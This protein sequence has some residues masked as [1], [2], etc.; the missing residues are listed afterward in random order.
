MIRHLFKLVWNR[1]R[2]NLLLMIE[3]LFSF[4]VL[5]AVTSMAFSSFHKYLKPRG[6]EFE[7]VWVLHLGWRALELEVPD[8]DLKN[9]LTQLELE[10]KSHEEISHFSWAT[11]CLPFMRQIWSTDL[12]IEGQE[13]NANVTVVGNDYINQLSI[14]IRGFL[15]ERKPF[16]K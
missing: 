13:I 8:E 14:F 16:A 7:N 4:I 10:M 6:F 5:F 3:I 9:T 12:N 11:G 15:I 2:S 1:K